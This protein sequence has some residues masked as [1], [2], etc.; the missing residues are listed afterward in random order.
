M[1][2]DF[3]G[4]ENVS[5]AIELSKLTKFSISRMTDKG[6]YTSSKYTNTIFNT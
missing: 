1:Q 4:L 2:T 5:K 3:I 6:S